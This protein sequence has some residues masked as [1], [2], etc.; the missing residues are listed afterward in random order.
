MFQSSLL[1]LPYFC[2]LCIS[3][4]CL[5]SFCLLCYTFPSLPGGFWQFIFKEYIV[6]SSVSRHG[7]PICRPCHRVIGYGAQLSHQD[8]L[9]IISEV[10]SFEWVGF[11][12]KKVS[13]FLP[14]DVKLAEHILGVQ[15]GKGGGKGSGGD[16]Q[17]ILSGPKS[18]AVWR[19]SQKYSFQHP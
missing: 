16:G 8:T 19:M 2:F 3:F 13:S 9:K 11:F 12:R 10:F 7:W 15:Q 6:G 4:S 17:Q 5:F 14:N 1:F 18:R